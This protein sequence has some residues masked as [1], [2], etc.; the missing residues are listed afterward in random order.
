MA[1]DNQWYGEKQ[2]SEKGLAFGNFKNRIVR[3]VLTEK[4]TYDCTPKESEEMSHTD[5]WRK[6]VS[7]SR[8]SKFRGPE[9]RI[10]LVHSTTAKKVRAVGVEKTRKRVVKM[11]VQKVMGRQ[12]MQ[13]PVGYYK[14]CD[15]LLRWKRKSLQ[16]RLGVL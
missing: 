7:S 1:C 2:H 9:A 10:C 8:N 13:G 12:I 3:E 11:E 6:K 14:E 5:I 4:M 16:T 15:F